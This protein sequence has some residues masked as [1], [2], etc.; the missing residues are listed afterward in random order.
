MSRLLQCAPALDLYR[1]ERTTYNEHDVSIR[2]RV[3][4]HHRVHPDR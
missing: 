1:R 4:A 2:L 3:M